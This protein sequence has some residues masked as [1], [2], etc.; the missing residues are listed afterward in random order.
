MLRTWVTR[1]SRSYAL[2]VTVFVLACVLGYAVVRDAVRQTVE[3]QALAIAE[4]VASQATT[5]RSVYA[6]EVAE[7]LRKDG[8][9]PDVNFANLP[10]HVPIPAQ[11]LKL[12][13]LSASA[14][15]DK[16]FAYRPVSKW[17]LEGSQ[18]LSDDFLLWAWPQLENQ[19]QAAPKEAIA[20]RSVSRIETHDGQR[21]L[22]FLKADP[23]SQMSCVT[24]HNAYEKTAPILSLRASQGVA[25]GKQW[26]QH[27]LMGALSVTVPLEKAELLAGN[28][29]NEAS[30]L[31]GGILVATFV[32]MFWFK[33]RT[34]QQ[35]RS[36]K[37]SA[38]NANRTKS[39]FLA[40]MS[41][42][43]RTPMIGVIGM[44]DLALDTELTAQQR[45]YLGT[46]K[47]SAQTLMVILNDFLDFSKIEAGKLAIEQVNFSVAELVD[48]TL[49]AVGAR[50]QKKNLPLVSTVPSDLP[51]HFLG[52]PGRI[53]Q[54]L[55][56]LCDNAIKF[57]TTGSVRIE[58][59][60]SRLPDDSFEV[61]FAVRDTGIGIPTD[62]Q[63]QV[64]EAFSQADTS[65]TRKFGG[66]GL[67]LSI[68]K[69]LVQLMGGRMWLESTPGAGSSFYFTV[70]L[71]AALDDSIDS[72]MPTPFTP[73][74]A[75][76]QQRPLRVLLVED[77]PI[78][79]KL[80]ITLLSK[81]GHEV[82]LAQNGQEGVDLF[83]SSAWDVVLMDIQMPVMNGLEA[84]RIIRAREP[85]G[86][87]TPI[88]AMTAN[89]MESDRTACLEAGMD[90]HMGKP[91]KAESLQK[92]LL[93]YSTKP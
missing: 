16:L 40:N 33:S 56:N 37:L 5:A 28:Q 91:F 68:C 55:T 81:W 31:F 23:A 77:H 20:W 59:R 22:R 12:V 44:T 34:E 54:V 69:Q 75:P 85:A 39:E 15:S 67:G 84:T 66:T 76:A 74:P 14:D 1:F 49:K 53:R 78:N 29:I 11:F 8:F 6:K 87:H 25:P 10:G 35:L 83:A 65:T 89:A 32:V 26:A 27:Q 7:K 63:G 57:T 47:G 51:T 13:G 43:I 18:G 60:W 21:V 70:H 52:D 61:Q 4:V 42:E 82:V 90:E 64:F 79:Q 86:Q 36:A 17:N 62:M 45:D 72:V 19:D 73:A 88:I 3:H 92:L 30:L 46:V 38:E 9:G 41:H 80:A 58:V 50:A 93:K 24:C 2:L 48:Q 71:L